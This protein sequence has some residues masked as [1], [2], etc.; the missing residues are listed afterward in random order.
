MVAHV[1]ELIENAWDES[2]DPLVTHRSHKSHGLSYQTG[3]SPPG[4][5]LRRARYQN[6][7]VRL[8][9]SSLAGCLAPN[10]SPFEKTYGC[11]WLTP[12]SMERL[13]H[14]CLLGH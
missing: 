11:N 6:Q 9:V 10:R 5:W 3:S 1:P 2:L 8:W 4:L 12:Q 14:F 7:V 13:K